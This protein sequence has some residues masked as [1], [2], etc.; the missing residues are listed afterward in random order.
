MRTY[1]L[2]QLVCV[3]I[4][5]EEISDFFYVKRKKF[6][7]IEEFEGFVLSKFSDL[8]YNIV[9]S[10]FSD[11]S[12]N[13]EEISELEYNMEEISELEEFFIR[14][15]KLYV[16]SRVMLNFSDGSSEVFYFNTNKEALDYHNSVTN[17]LTNKISI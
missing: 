7:W 9:L 4:F 6:L 3:E 10:K 12:Y 14:D 8:S 15:F 13:M 1:N 11:L 2:D 5:E 16:K 17:K